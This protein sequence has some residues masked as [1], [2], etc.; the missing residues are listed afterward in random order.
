MLLLSYILTGALEMA[1]VII[2]YQAKARI[3]LWF[4]VFLLFATLCSIPLELGELG[5]KIRYEMYQMG[6][7]VSHYD[8]TAN[9]LKSL[10]YFLSLR[11]LISL[12]TGAILAYVIIISSLLLAVYRL[13]K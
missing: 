9:L 11:N 6:I 4:Y 2:V 13:N 1:L 10:V 3:L 12:S 5:G 7:D 8:L